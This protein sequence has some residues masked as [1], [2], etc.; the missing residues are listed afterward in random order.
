MRLSNIPFRIESTL[1]RVGYAALGARP[2]SRPFVSGDTFRALGNLIY[3]GGILKNVKPAGLGVVPIVF[4]HSSEIP[5]FSSTVLE[6]Y[7]VDM[8]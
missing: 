8:F 2:T 6:T 1:V 7:Q 5:T 3:E 4:V